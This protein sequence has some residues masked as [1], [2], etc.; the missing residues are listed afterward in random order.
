MADV[1]NSSCLRR[2]CQHR[3]KDFEVEV[4]PVR[5][6]VAPGS[7]AKMQKDIFDQEFG[8]FYRPQQ[9]FLMDQEAYRDLPTLRHN[10]SSASLA[11]LP[12][13][14]SWKRLLWLA[15]LEKEVRELRTPSGKTLQDV[16]VA[17]AGAGTPCV[18]QSILGYFQDDPIGYGLDADSWDQALDHA[19]A[20]RRMLADLRTAPE[21]KHR[22]WW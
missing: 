15:D 12:P 17:P 16:C 1:R 9:I 14:L 21:T 13:A 6:W 10:S 2:P 20:I 19:V 7:T 8:P 11:A 18:V 3:W 4:D 5:L 22:A